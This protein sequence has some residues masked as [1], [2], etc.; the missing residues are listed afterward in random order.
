MAYWRQ[1]QRPLVEIGIVE[2]PGHG[3]RGDNDAFLRHWYEVSSAIS[4]GG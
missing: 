4:V 2:R 3:S 1:M